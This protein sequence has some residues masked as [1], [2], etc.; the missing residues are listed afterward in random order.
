[1]SIKIIQ[2][3]EHERIVAVVPQRA[4]G[5]G[6]G[7]SPTWVHIVDYANNTHREECIQPEERTPELHALYAPA[8]AMTEALLAAVP[9][10]K[11]R[12]KRSAAA[13]G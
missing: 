7:N 8:A 11:A 10:K 3:S 13:N 4:A 1:M 9:V 12:T 5:P 2:L 6:W